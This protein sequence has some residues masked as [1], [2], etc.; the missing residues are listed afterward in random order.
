MEAVSGLLAESPPA[1]DCLLFT[2]Y[3]L[4][5]KMGLASSAVPFPVLSVLLRVVIIAEVLISGVGI[6]YF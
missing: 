4:L 5:T 2:N 6:L 1:A 3:Y